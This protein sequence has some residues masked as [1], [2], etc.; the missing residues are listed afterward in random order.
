MKSDFRPIVRLAAP[1]ELR[2]YVVYEHQLDTLKQGQPAGLMLNFA[3]FLLG[4]A[5]TGFGTVVA[6]PAGQNKAYNTFLIITLVTTIAGA[7]LFV[8]WLVLRRS[9]VDLVAE[10][11]AQMPP[12]PEAE[13]VGNGAGSS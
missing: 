3:L 10:I 9:L 1:G 6:L 13:Q 4:V 8:L 5:A 12:N 2:A 7:V 11:K